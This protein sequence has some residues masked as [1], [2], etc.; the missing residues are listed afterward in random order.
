VDG[1]LKRMGYRFVLRRF[2]HPARVA[3]QGKLAFTSWW[4]NKGVAP[5][6]R[7]FPLAVRLAGEKTSAVMLTSADIRK[8]LPGDIVHDDAVFVPA[9][10]GGR[11]IPDRQSPRCGRRHASAARSATSPEGVRTAGTTWGI[12]VQGAAE[13]SRDTQSSLLYRRQGLWRHRFRG[14]RERPCRAPPSGTG[15]LAV[16]LGHCP[17]SPAS[18]AVRFPFEKN[19]ML[20]PGLKVHRID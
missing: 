11:R 13:G 3:P 2:A 7:E 6:Y 9:D 10:L 5:C 15:A 16:R 14:D 4:E 20:D 19:V 8:W 1:W 12:T 18:A 17:A